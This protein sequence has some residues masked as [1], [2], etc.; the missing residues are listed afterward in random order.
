[1]ADKDDYPG[2]GPRALRPLLNTEI[3]PMAVRLT[4]VEGFVLSRVDGLTS[5]REITMVTGLP[6]DQTL[7]IMRE[8]KMVG[9]IF[10]PGE[11]PLLSPRG[12]TPSAPPP[13]TTVRPRSGSPPWPSLLKRLDDGS[14]VDPALLMAAPELDHALK[15]SIIRVHRRAPRLDAAGLL[16]VTREAGPQDLKKAYLG[17]SKELHPDRYYGKDIGHFRHKLEDL[18]RRCTDAF[19]QLN[20]PFKKKR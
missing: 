7:R 11:T 5:Y 18:F 19:N 6:P 4:P 1:M 3:D 12:R 17:A 10:N 13:A 16:G 15:T 20:E 9:L 14:P 2:L 8:L